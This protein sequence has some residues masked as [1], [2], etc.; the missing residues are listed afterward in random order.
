MEVKT[1]EMQCLD[2]W[3]SKPAD[4][5]YNAAN[6][7]DCALG[8]F[9]KTIGCEPGPITFRDAS[10]RDHFLSDDLLGAAYRNDDRKEAWTFGQAAD[11]LEALLSS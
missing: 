9:A 1:L 8:Q 10:G 11:R 7:S 6:Y 5:R 4:E 2:F 3:R